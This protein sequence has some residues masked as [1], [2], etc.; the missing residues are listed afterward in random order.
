MQTRFFYGW[1]V[2]F[3]AAVC[4]GFGIG[5]AYVSWGFFA[6]EM[7]AELGFSRE[8][9]GAVFGLFSF[10]YS[11]LGIVV[12]LAQ[13]RLGIRGVM[14]LGFTVSALG[15]FLMSRAQSILDCYLAFA[16]L[17]GGGIG[18]STVIPCQALGQN[19]FLKRRA[20]AIAV[21]M[22]AG[23]VVIAIYPQVNRLVLEHGSWRT[24]WLVIAGISAALVVF[25]LAVVRDRPEDLGLSR[26]GAAPGAGTAPLAPRRGMQATD[27]LWTARRAIRTPQFVLLI[28]CGI[29]YVLP[30]GVL[31]SHGRLF[32]QDNGFDVGLIATLFSSV[33]LVS[34][35]G[36]L[37]GVWGDWV[38]PQAVLAAA[39]T[40]EALGTGALLLADTP[41][42][43]YAS[44]VLLGLGFGAA[45]TSIPVTFTYFFGRNAFVTTTALRILITGAVN[46]M[47]PWLAGRVFDAT[48][49]YAIPFVALVVIT[50]VGALAAT[51]CR[52]P[53]TA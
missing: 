16:L 5:P 25:T 38:P 48:Q 32:F 33:A 11:A 34:I 37:A 29:A 2:L 47:A 30:W 7:I 44:I 10:L 39:L 23:G 24:G 27:D 3:A 40:L 52:H 4:Y 49:S 15:F 19:W 17:G 8:Q 13:R 14:A 36:R 12:G 18:L 41:A 45:Y 43:A 28:F 42:K 50:L 35:A 31:F 20:F 22:A 53:G 26:D 1:I 21:I 9:I 46:A 51:A 6:P